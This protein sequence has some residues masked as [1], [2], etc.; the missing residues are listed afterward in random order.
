MNAFKL[1][2]VIL[3]VILFIIAGFSSDIEY[4]LYRLDNASREYVNI[5]EKIGGSVS[6][7][8]PNNFAEV[9]LNQ[10]QY[11]EL[12][13]RGYTLIQ[14]IDRDKVYADSLYEATKYTPRDYR[15]S[16]DLGTTIFKY[17]WTAF[18]RANGTRQGNVDYE[19]QW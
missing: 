4:K 9:Y 16:S 11:D 3:F 10:N 1:N 13:K 17:S 8:F 18:D 7:Y 14:I 6:R 5:V 2:F 12:V 15:Y 19:N